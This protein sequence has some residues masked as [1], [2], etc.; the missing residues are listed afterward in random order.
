[1]IAN[2]LA[3][4]PGDLPPDFSKGLG[5]PVVAGYTITRADGTTLK[6]KAGQTATIDPATA[7]PLVGNMVSSSSRGPSYSYNAIKPDIGAPGASVSAV[8]GTGT[9][10]EAFGGTSGAAPMVTGSAALLIQ[11]FPHI[12][13]TEVKARL[14]N[15]AETNIG[16]NPVGLPG[17]LAPITRIGGGEVRVDRAIATTT[18]AWDAEDQTG[19]LSFGYAALTGSKSFQKT[20]AVRKYSDETRTYTITPGFRYADDAASGAVTI[21]APATIKVKA[22]RTAYFN[23]KVRVDASKLP[24]WN[25]NGGLMG[26]DGYRLQAFEFDGYINIADGTDN[27]HVAWQILPHRAADVIPSRNNLNLNKGTGTLVLKN[28]D[29]ALDGRVDV[30]SLL[31]TSE[32]IQKKYLPG[33]GDNYAVVDL[34][35]FGARM[36]DI[37]GGL[38]GIQFAINTFGARAHPNYPAE[39][40]IYIDNNLDGVDDFVIYNYENGGFGAT[41]QNLVAVVDLN[42]SAGGAYFYSDAD[43]NSSNIIM[44]APLSALGLTPSTQFNV[45]VYAFDNYF[46]GSLTDSITGMT[47]TAG[48]PRYY[49]DNIAPVVP[50]GGGTTLNISASPGGDNASPSQIGLL[51]MYRDAR[52]QREADTLIIRP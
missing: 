9:G 42:T 49:A 13:P 2:N 26:G 15:T 23:V 51:F 4:A 20:V 27:I 24:V 43:L 21:S 35:D 38:Y 44:T 10:Q 25:L 12:T 40:D 19:S 14:M 47:Y 32:R 33:D 46:T 18:A 11:K 6:T 45:S 29:G 16:I 34:K 5:N 30:F 48:T 37:G 36:V 7:A 22:N 28:R 1:V 52:Q 8:Y 17:Y 39:F 50:M 3:Q 31:G 41:G